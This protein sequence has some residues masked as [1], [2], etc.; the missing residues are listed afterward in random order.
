MHGTTLTDWISRFLKDRRSR[1][2]RLS[3]W[4]LEDLGLGYIAVPKVASSSIRNMIRQREGQRLFPGRKFS[5]RELKVAVEK[6]VRMSATPAQVL[7]L[8]ER[9]HLFSFARNPLMRLHSCY[10]DKVVNAQSQQRRC[11]LSPYGI[12]FGISFD[13]FV[14]RVAA[15]PDDRS[16][17]H[18][19][20]QHTFLTHNGQLLVHT[21][22]KMESI[23]EDWRPFTEKYGL[24]Q[25][26]R[27]RRVSGPPMSMDSLPLSKRC[28]ALAIERYRTDIDLLGYAPEIAAWHEA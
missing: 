12:Q 14:E 19:R 6:H 4:V 10:R 28:A 24:A 23:D 16:D 9:L 22:G 11:S 13:A 17:Q 26:T 20:S 5:H 18:F 2:N 27:E 25:P 8:R 15:I 3:V 7:A 1:R 21:L